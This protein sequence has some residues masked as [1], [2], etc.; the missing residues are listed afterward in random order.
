[1][2]LISK[3]GKFFWVIVLTFC[4]WAWFDLLMGE[5]SLFDVLLTSALTVYFF[6]SGTGRI[7]S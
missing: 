6:L 2:N 1:M 7:K 5:G 4:L 3:Y